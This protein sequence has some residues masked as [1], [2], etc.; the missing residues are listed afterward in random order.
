MRRITDFIF[1]ILIALSLLGVGCTRPAA[2][3]TWQQDNN[4]ATG[5]TMAP[6]TP[7][8]LVTETGAIPGTF[9]DTIMQSLLARIGGRVNRSLSSLDQNVSGAAT[10]LGVTGISGSAA[11]GILGSLAASPSVVDAVTV[12][13]DGKITAVMSAGYLAVIGDNVADQSH[14]RTVLSTGAPVLSGEFRTMEGFS[15]SAVVYP[16]RSANGTL[17]GLVSVP[18]LTEHLLSDAISPLVDDRVYEV[19]VIQADGRIIYATNASQVG[20]MS[21][22]DPLITSRPDLARFVNQV[23]STDSGRGT[24]S[25]F[26]TGTNTNKTV[27]NYWTT[28]SLHGA[29][30]RIILDTVRE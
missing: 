22:S 8:H 26:D 5:V 19:T 2:P 23:I 30:W 3:E 16:V 4:I 21:L 12:T 15:A 11:N 20:M 27:E 6:T 9:N 1:I 13:N 25:V 18:F 24:Y 14:I 28:V 7:V 17:I 29:P 10:S